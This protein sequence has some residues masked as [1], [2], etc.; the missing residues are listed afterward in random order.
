M[1]IQN[2]ILKDDNL[3]IQNATNVTPSIPLNDNPVILR[4]LRRLKESQST[5]HHCSHYTK[6]SSYSTKHSSGW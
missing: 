5:D 3:N 2:E 6:H 1:V 4:A